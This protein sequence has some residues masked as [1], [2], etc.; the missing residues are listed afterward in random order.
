MIPD[1]AL[2]SHQ[3]QNNDLSSIES[4]VISPEIIQILRPL[5]LSLILVI[6]YPV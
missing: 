4:Q 3:V 6:I 1:N 2:L 5:A